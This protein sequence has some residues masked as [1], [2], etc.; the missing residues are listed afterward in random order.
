MNPFLFFFKEAYF[1]KAEITQATEE[2]YENLIK[3]S[4]TNIYGFWFDKKNR[5]LF[6]IKPNLWK[7]PRKCVWSGEIFTWL[8]LGGLGLLLLKI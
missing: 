8:Y 7:K 6:E 4:L 5:L 2:Y 3:P 1:F